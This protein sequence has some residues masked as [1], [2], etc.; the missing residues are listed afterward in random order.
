MC[1]YI[2][3]IRDDTCSYKTSYQAWEC[4]GYDYEMLMLESM[5]QDTETR[6]VSPVAVLG[7]GFVDLVNGPQDHGWCLGYT[8]QKRLSIFPIILAMGEF[9]IIINCLEIFIQK[10][11]YFGNILEDNCKVR[12]IEN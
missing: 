1:F 4:H 6:R 12:Y 9:K 11:G 8:C 3:I 7:E 5:D 2:G 10:N